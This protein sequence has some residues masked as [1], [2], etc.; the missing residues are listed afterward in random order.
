MD[1]DGNPVADI[2]QD[3]GDDQQNSGIHQ[4]KF[5]LFLQNDAFV[6]KSGSG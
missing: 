3:G 4:R 6:F 5:Q 1:P 2:A